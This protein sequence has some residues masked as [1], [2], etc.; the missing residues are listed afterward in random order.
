M[1]QINIDEIRTK[2]CEMSYHE[3]NLAQ[4]QAER[5]RNNARANRDYPRIQACKDL[6][7]DIDKLRH[8]PVRMTDVKLPPQQ[9]RP[10]P[11]AKP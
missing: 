7:R 10:T 2:M 4:S 8:S 5:D 9:Q 1:A 11:P 6:M 3:L